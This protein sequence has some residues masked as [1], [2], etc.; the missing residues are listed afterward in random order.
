MTNNQPS[1]FERS[2]FGDTAPAE[3]PSNKVIPPK[4]SPVK[5]DDLAEAFLGAMGAGLMVA[6]I[7]KEDAD[8]V[9]KALED[10][11][12]DAAA[13]FRGRVLAGEVSL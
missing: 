10:I 3:A 2:I 8:A 12:S 13:R 1:D 6:I 9:T 4:E 11:A 7:L 5:G